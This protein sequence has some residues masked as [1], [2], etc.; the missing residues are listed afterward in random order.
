MLWNISL[1]LLS[2][3]CQE[4]LWLFLKPLVRAN[5]IKSTPFHQWL[6]HQPK[7]NQPAHGIG[8]FENMSAKETEK[9]A[10]GFEGVPKRE[11]QE[12]CSFFFPW[13]Q[14]D[15]RPQNPGL[16]SNPAE[17]WSQQTGGQSQKHRETELN[18]HYVSLGVYSTSGLPFT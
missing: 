10:G 1:W 5:H 7:P 18:L 3:P 2:T 17:G 12:K 15:V 4:C 6:V 9:F 16:I 8:W 11:P 13:L 14:M